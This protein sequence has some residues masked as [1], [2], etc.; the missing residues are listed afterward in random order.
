MYDSLY[1]GSIKAEA[2]RVLRNNKWGIAIAVSLVTG[3]LTGGPMAVVRFQLELTELTGGT[4][5]FSSLFIGLLV[6]ILI[7]SLFAPA[8]NMGV[9]L[10][11]IKLCRGERAGFGDAFT[12]FSSPKYILKALGLQLV[13]GVFILLWSL[14]LI[15]PGIIAAY[16]YS[17]AMYFMARNPE[18][19]IFEAINESKVYMDGNKMSLFVLQL[20]FIG[21]AFLA[22]LTCGIGLLFLT[23]YMETS[24][25]VFFL[26]V[27][28][29][30]SVDD[31]ND[32]E[33]V[34]INNFN[35]NEL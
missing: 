8:I 13:M 27:A 7:A 25:A 9:T 17:L 23:P 31:E 11:Y 12:F 6:L 24:N 26:R 16:R 10:F 34:P 22:V 18:M 35:E 15:I 3:L 30:K 4:V 20:S 28:G 19:G 21:W 5:V 2:L 14:L 32:G 1:S 29:I 33:D